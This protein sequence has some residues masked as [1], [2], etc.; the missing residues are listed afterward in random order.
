MHID[1]V[2]ASHSVQGINCI[3]IF[4]RY[5]REQMEKLQAERDQIEE[6]RA[7]SKKMMEELQRLQAQLAA[8]GVDT[9]QEE[10]ADSNRE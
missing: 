3:R 6:E 5:K 4:R 8:N 7:E 2:P 1:S 9:K 10:T